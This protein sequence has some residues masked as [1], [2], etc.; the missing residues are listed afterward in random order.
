MSK[1][2]NLLPYG[3]KPVSFEGIPVKI[4]LVSNAAGFGVFPA[5]DRELEQRLTI[6]RDGRVWFS[7]YA[8]ENYFEKLKKELQRDY[9]PW[10]FREKS[11][12]NCRKR[13]DNS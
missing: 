13:F 6:H 9:F 10:P 2:M 11:R 4:Q 7:G 12:R 5:P 3:D 1:I 8:Y